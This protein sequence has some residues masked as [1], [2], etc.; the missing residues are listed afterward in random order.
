MLRHSSCALD[1]SGGTKRYRENLAAALIKAKLK[2]VADELMCMDT[3][4]VRKSTLN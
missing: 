4:Q 3:I 2:N 1:G